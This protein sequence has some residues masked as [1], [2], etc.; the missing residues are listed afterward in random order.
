MV[1]NVTPPTS[2]NGLYPH[3]PC[4]LLA[5]IGI[6]P[7]AGRP[8]VSCSN[9]AAPGLATRGSSK[10]GVVLWPPSTRPSTPPAPPAWITH[11]HPTTLHFINPPLA[12]LPR[13]LGEV[14]GSDTDRGKSLEITTYKN[15][16]IALAS[17]AEANL[18]A[19]R[20]RSEH[21]AINAER[22]A[23]EPPLIASSAIQLQSHPQKTTIPPP[24]TTAEPLDVHEQLGPTVTAP[25]P[26]D[27]LSLS[28]HGP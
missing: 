8:H 14:P 5:R 15:H 26:N 6:S 10:R 19:V 9:P 7:I 25:V 18:Q 22:G 24:A 4:S 27:D 20:R 2:A 12:P 17:N 3:P 13:E 11:S 21:H 16:N 28:R 23:T 1:D